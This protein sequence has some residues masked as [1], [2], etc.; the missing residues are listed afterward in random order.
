LIPATA[1]AARRGPFDSGTPAG[2]GRNPSA[3]LPEPGPNRWDLATSYDEGITD[4]GFAP[5]CGVPNPA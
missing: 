1:L 5:R 3:T 4:E 2:P